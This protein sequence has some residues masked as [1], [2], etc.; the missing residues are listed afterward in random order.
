MPGRTYSQQ[1]SGPQLGYCPKCDGP[2]MPPPPFSTSMDEA[3]RSFGQP[4][5]NMDSLDDVMRDVGGNRDRDFRER[6]V[7]PSWRSQGPEPGFVRQRSELLNSEPAPLPPPSRNGHSSNALA[8]GGPPPSTWSG[9]PEVRAA[10]QSTGDKFVITVDVAD[11]APEE[12]KVKTVDQSVVVEGK[13]EENRPG[14]QR[15]VSRNFSRS[16]TIPSDVD[17][18]AITSKL[19]ANG[20][21][22]IE[23][24][25][26]LPPPPRSRE[27]SIPVHHSSQ[28]RF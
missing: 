27:Q 25:R 20:R 11:Y 28:R 12:I 16:W 17:P 22:T 13:H 3:F 8:R 23:A 9:I 15:Y 18:V 6:E 26:K 21:L 2:L 24:P 5:P 14:G 4:P 1:G 19:S 7:Y 10:E